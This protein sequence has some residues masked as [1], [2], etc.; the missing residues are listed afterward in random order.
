[1]QVGWFRRFKSGDFDLSNKDRGK[2]PK[3]FEDAEVQALLD[4]DSTQTLKH[5]AKAFRVDQGNI[6][7]RLHAIGKIQKE[8]KW[9]PYELKERDIERRKTT[10]EI[11]FDRFER[12]SFCI[13][14][15]LAKKIGSISTIPSAKKS[16]VDPR[17]P[18]TS[19]PVRNIHGK[20]ALLCSLWD[21]K[22]C[23]MNC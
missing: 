13:A 7:R 22:L 8:G 18:S 11:L 12:K 23:T 21:Q 16:W 6:S 4:E 19:Q 1:M 17:Q 20:N 15:L 2:P 3:K 10:C 5:L 9:V 14:L